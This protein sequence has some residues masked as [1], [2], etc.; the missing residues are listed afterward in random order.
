M[1]PAQFVLPR[2]NSSCDTSAASAEAQAPLSAIT[3]ISTRL[4]MIMFRLVF[5]ASSFLWAFARSARPIGEMKNPAP[6]LGGREHLAPPFPPRPRAQP[7]QPAPE[8]H[9]TGRERHRCRS[10]NHRKPLEKVGPDR[11]LLVSLFSICLFLSVI[12]K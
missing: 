12:R 5:I 3:P 9:P 7:D 4:P 1:S 8:E 6:P 2:V 10:P 11:P